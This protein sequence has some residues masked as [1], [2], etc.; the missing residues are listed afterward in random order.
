MGIL[1][2]HA[3]VWAVLAKVLGYGQAVENALTCG[4][5]QLQYEFSVSAMSLLSFNI[6]VEHRVCTLS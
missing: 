4:P 6:V 3:S 1:L 5:L 2:Q